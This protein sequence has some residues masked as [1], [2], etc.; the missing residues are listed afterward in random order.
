MRD[1]EH[2]VRS[3]IGRIDEIALAV[4]F[5]GSTVD[6]GM[7][8][9]DLPLVD[10]LTGCR[11]GGG[12][13]KHEHAAVRIVV[14]ASSSGAIIDVPFAT[15]AVQFR[16]PDRLRVRTGFRWRPDGS[17]FGVSEISEIFGLPDRQPVP[18]S[19]HVIISIAVACHPRIGAGRQ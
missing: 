14:M 16:R 1:I 4:I 7:G 19:V 2:A 15:D 17:G 10:P 3:D 9:I 8:R 6:A 18:Q 11:I 12:I 13:F 5:K